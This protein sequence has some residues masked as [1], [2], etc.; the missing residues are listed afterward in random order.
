MM[1]FPRTFWRGGI[2]AEVAL[3]ATSHVRAS[4]NTLASAKRRALEL[5]ERF[6]QAFERTVLPEQPDYW[7]V[8]DFLIRARRRMADA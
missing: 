1:F 6:Q 5:G 4:C 2:S 3:S 8:E 7:R